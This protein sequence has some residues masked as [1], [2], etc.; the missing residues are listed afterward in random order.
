MIH[1]SVRVLKQNIIFKVVS[2][3]GLAIRGKS[4]ASVGL[5]GHTGVLMTKAVV[6]AVWAPS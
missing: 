3:L 6:A 5:L 2:M 4:L 1:L